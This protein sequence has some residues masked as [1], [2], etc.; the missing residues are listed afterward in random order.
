MKYSTLT[1]LLASFSVIGCFSPRVALLDKQGT[2]RAAAQIHN[3]ASTLS[4]NY[5][6][7][8][9]IHLPTA[10]GDFPAKSA[11][12][13]GKVG[14]TDVAF[15][16]GY[17]ITA[18]A[19]ALE[20]LPGSSGPGWKVEK[21]RPLVVKIPVI[22]MKQYTFEITDERPISAISDKSI[23]RNQCGMITWGLATK[24]YYP[25]LKGHSNSQLRSRE[26]DADKLGYD[27]EFRVRLVDEHASTMILVNSKTV[28]VEVQ[29]VRISNGTVYAS[30]RESFT[31]TQGLIND[32]FVNKEL[33]ALGG[34][35]SAA[36]MKLPDNFIGEVQ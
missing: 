24:G 31:S 33:D 10:P 7:V 21:S 6:T 23:A 5:R 26:S 29:L 22:R 12:A 14:A 18:N 28:A 1:I 4:G 9:V 16:Q 3:T 11:V 34:A 20:K 35:I 30:A 27:L 8:G 13:A 17:P 25:V 2:P 32:A 15:F 36:I 19:L